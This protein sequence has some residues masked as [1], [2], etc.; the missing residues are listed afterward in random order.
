VLISAGIRAAAHISAISLVLPASPL[1]VEIEDGRLDMRL[2]LTYIRVGSIQS[3][4]SD[5]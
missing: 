3:T 1:T 4:P 2:C 5:R